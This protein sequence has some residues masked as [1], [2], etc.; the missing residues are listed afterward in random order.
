MTCALPECDQAEI[1]QGEDDEGSQP[2]EIDGGSDDP[3]HDHAD[4]ERDE[5]HATGHL[6]PV[7]GIRLERRD[8]KIIKMAE[9]NSTSNER[10]TS[11][12]PGK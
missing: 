2:V 8:R 4:R 10:P 3:D 1:G 9:S 5:A 7:V 6:V 12:L 11:S